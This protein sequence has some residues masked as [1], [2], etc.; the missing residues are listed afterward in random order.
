MGFLNNSGDIILDAVLTDDGRKRL[1][2]GDGTFNI[3]RFALGDDEID[4][5]QWDGSNANGSA[6]YDLNILQTP[7]LEA[8]TNNGSSMKSKLVSYSSTDILYLPIMMLNTNSVLQGFSTNNTTLTFIGIV[9]VKDI[10]SGV[11]GDVYGY[12]DT[13]QNSFQRGNFNATAEGVIPSG[14]LITVDQGL[15]TDAITFKDNL[16][17]I[18]EETG[19]L[20]TMD[21]RLCTLV[22]AKATQ[23]GD[24]QIDDDNMATYIVT[25]PTVPNCFVTIT[26]NDANPDTTDSVLAGPFNTNRLKFSLQ[27]TTDLRYSNYYFTTFGNTSDVLDT[28]YNSKNTVYS[29]DTSIQVVGLTTGYRLDIPVRFVKFLAA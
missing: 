24:A 20:I 11:A 17:T 16:E 26:D 14:Q 18:Y 6:Y 7:I 4:Y 27:A 25:R 1:S 12:S 22:D 13:T 23:V 28:Q 2:K 21:N 15:N 3:V 8:F 29:L 10:S 19:Y 5:G 9:N